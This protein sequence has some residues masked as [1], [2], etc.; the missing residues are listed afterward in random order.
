VLRHDDAERMSR[1]VLAVSCLIALVHG[2]IYISYLRPDWDVAWTDQAGYKQLGSVLARTGTFTRYPDYPV[3]VP[4]VIRTPGYP[5]FVAPIY[6]V[7]GVGND[8]AVTAV[9]VVLFAVLC[10]LVYALT[11]RLAG[12]RAA[13]LAALLTALFAPL[14]HFAA[15]VLTEFWTTFVATAAMLVVLSA[16]QRQ[17]LRDFALGGVLLSAVTLVRPAFVLLPFFLASAMPVLLRSQRTAAALR[18]WG[19][20]AVTA[21]LTLLPWF[22]YNYVNLGQFTLSPAGGIGRGLWEGSWQGVWPGRVQAQLT[23]IAEQ[24]TDVEARV[25]TVARESGLDPRPMLQYVREWRTNHDLWDT[26]QDPLERARARV[27]ADR[28]YLDAALNNIRQDPIGHLMRRVTRGTFVLWA[29]DIPIRYSDINRTPTIVIRVV[30]LIQVVILLLAVAGAV[31]LARRGRRV[32]AVLLVLPLVYVTAVHLPLL[33]EA[34]QS[35]PVKP[36]V[37]ALA[38][39]AMSRLTSPGSADS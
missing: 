9:Q 12:R 1:I 24:N 20:L 37:L 25:H 34:R 30:W 29:A 36:L 33:C 4:E 22:T 14:P 18:G 31:T 19:V 32:E 11:K 17:R 16:V 10:G 8:V 15:L 13:G 5:A 39:V 2:A 38:A 28:A 35:L 6:R 26:P 27:D 7:F 3:F 21:A 23:A